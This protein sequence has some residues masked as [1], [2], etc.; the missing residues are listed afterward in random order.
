MSKYFDREGSLKKPYVEQAAAAFEAEHS[1]MPV[2][3]SLSRYYC[4]RTGRVTLFPFRGCT[5]VGY[6][7]RETQHDWCRFLDGW[8]ACLKMLEVGK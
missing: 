4:G 8:C 1:K 3:S 7:D 2:Y 5:W 6:I